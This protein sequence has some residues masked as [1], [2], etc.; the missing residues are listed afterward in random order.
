VGELVGFDAPRSRWFEDARGRSLK[1]S[2]HPEAGL[3]VISLWESDRCIGTF[4]LP[5]ADA[6]E[7]MVLLAGAVRAWAEDESA[8]SSRPARPDENLAPA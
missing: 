2:W 5:A 7:L 8:V 1:A 4:R 6:P 3:V